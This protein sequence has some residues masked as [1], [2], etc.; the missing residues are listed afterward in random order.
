MTIFSLYH[1]LTCYLKLSDAFNV[2]I[3]TLL[4]Q[5]R[6]PIM[7]FSEKLNDSRKNYS[8]F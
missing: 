6:K 4:S 7:F 1:I 8:P 3:D 5:E 2:G